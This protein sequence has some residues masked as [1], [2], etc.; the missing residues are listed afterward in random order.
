MSK[1]FFVLITLSNISDF[2]LTKTNLLAKMFML[3][4]W[5][6]YNEN[7]AETLLN[8]EG[9]IARDQV[10]IIGEDDVIIWK[11][12]LTTHLNYL[13]SMENLIKALGSKPITEETSTKVKLLI[14]NKQKVNKLE[15]ALINKG[16]KGVWEVM[17]SFVGDDEDEKAF[18]LSEL[19]VYSR[20]IPVESVLELIGDKREIKL[21]NEYMKRFKPLMFNKNIE[22]SLRELFTSFR[23]AGVEAQTVERV[24]EQFGHFYFEFSE[25]FTT[26]KEMIHFANKKEAYDF[27][28]LLIMLHTWHHNPNIVNKTNFKWFVDSVKDLWKESYHLML[29]KD[30]QNIF[31]SIEEYEFDSPLTRNLR[32]KN[33]SLESLPI[34][35]DIRTKVRIDPKHSLNDSEFINWLL[36]K[37][38]KK[39]MHWN[40][41]FNVP[42]SL[43][44]LSKCHLTNMIFKDIKQFINENIDSPNFV[45]LFDKIIEICSTFEREDII[46]EIMIIWYERVHWTKLY[47]QLT[48][49]ELNLS[50]CLIVN[51]W[52]WVAKYKSLSQNV[53]TILSFAYENVIK[54]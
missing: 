46:E 7:I 54:L 28:Y 43:L 44:E 45:T 1:H 19:L 29:E 6:P 50:S 21:L 40:N 23:L 35:I 22:K 53:S 42:K 11:D 4:D 12:N 49:T 38:N 27:V 2:I 32:E 39:L 30:L 52:K 31:H 9:K 14:D 5:Q 17:Q 34:E 36:F 48:D 8:L 47:V 16:R 20:N 3:Y 33:F 51:L 10:A 18:K 24:L 37:S 25:T 13:N 41:N 15:N 26:D